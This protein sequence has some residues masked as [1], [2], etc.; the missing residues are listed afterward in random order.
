MDRAGLKD[1]CSACTSVSLLITVLVA[2]PYR[3]RR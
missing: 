1:L 2:H 3:P